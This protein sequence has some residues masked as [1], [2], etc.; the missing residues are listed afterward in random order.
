MVDSKTPALAVILAVTVSCTP[1]Q[2]VDDGMPTPRDSVARHGLELVRQGR[3]RLAIEKLESQQSLAPENPWV[4]FALGR[5]YAVEGHLRLA[6]D[7]YARA[8]ALEPDMP[9][10]AFDL[11]ALAY[12]DKRFESAEA[13]L[14]VVAADDPAANWNRVLIALRRRDLPG[15][16][17]RIDDVLAVRPEWAEAW[18]MR[19]LVDL[20]HKD[21]E[22]AREACE[23]LMM[24]Q[25][26]N[27]FAQMHAIWLAYRAGR[28]VE[29]E[30][31][32]D[33]LHRADSS[34]PDTPASAIKLIEANYPWKPT[35]PFLFKDWSGQGWLPM[36]PESLP[37]E[38]AR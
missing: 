12:R 8:Q 20:A 4:A 26:G 6:R 35:Q 38:P 1:W 15:A 14:A 30:T 10:A 32:V 24:R 23:A 3:S 29:M 2:R 28:H 22:G 13:H 11:A 19:V 33:R 16:R 7:Q 18:E 31:L 36:D 17:A 37:G 21:F 9:S 34:A 27:R 5:A 25:P